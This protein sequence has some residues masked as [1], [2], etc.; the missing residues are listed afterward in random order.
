ML[1][2]FARSKYVYLQSLAYSLALFTSCGKGSLMT[3]DME[4]VVIPAL[5]LPH[6]HLHVLA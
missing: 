5:D 6:K 3:G 2:G 4:F 1:R